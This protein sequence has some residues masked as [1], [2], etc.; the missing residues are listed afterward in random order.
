[1]R[2]ELHYLAMSSRD[3][4]S[5]KSLKTMK[6]LKQV[7][8]ILAFSFNSNYLIA[9]VGMEDISGPGPEHENLSS[10]VGEWDVALEMGK[11]NY[12]GS[13]TTSM[14]VGDRFLQVDFSVS[15]ESNT[16]EGIFFIGFDRRNDAY[17]V[18]GM[19]SFGTYF[20]TASG[21]AVEGFTSKAYGKD[22]DPM[23]KKMGFE[24]EFGY[25]LTFKE[26]DRFVIEIFWIDNRTDA[27]TEI[28]ALEY[29][30]I[31]SD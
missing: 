3:I 24:K 2:N 12:E 10:Y 26:K 18:L 7:I 8:V 15:N 9:Q 28:K 21:P 5:P 31:A 19:D 16:I 6:S 22:N 27:H 4:F 1:M 17:Q 23:M 20:V 30:F 13:S 25:N 14:I 29:V 11:E